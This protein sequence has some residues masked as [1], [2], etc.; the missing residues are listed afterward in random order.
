MESNHNKGGNMSNLKEQ[1]INEI[2]NNKIILFMKGD[3]NAP[4]CG[5]SATV[6]K[7]LNMYD[8]DYKSID[9]LANP[10]IRI[11]LSEYSNWPTIPQL[12]INGELVGGCD[13]AVELHN[14]GGLNKLLS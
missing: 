4:R 14:S 8:I 7:I 12:F 3:K 13:I 5:F 1:I 6:V 11:N 10:D 9:V 2:K